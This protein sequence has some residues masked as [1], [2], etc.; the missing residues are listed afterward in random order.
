MKPRLSADV[1]FYPFHLCHGE[2]LARLLA[3]FHRVH[4]RDYMAIR[5]TPLAG[6]TAYEDRM[7]AYFPEWVAQGRL[8]QGYNVSGPLSDQLTR[9]IDEDL[10]DPIWRGAFHQALIGNRR[11][12]RGLFDP[13]HAMKF[14]AELVPGPAGLLRLMHP[15]LGQHPFTVQ[16][17]RELSGRPQIGEAADRFEYGLAL[18]KT[19]AALHY[20]IELAGTH[21]LAAATDSPAHHELLA[22][23]LQREGLFLANHLII[24]HGY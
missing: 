12:Q 15:Q 22:R 18:V 8:I 9:A 1:L 3:R 23:T 6:T 21:D 13:T 16:E 10:A 14:G 11:F 2:T 24:R 5:L 20:T 4:V 19:S 17:V 7:G